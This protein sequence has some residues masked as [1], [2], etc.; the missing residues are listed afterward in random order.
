MH[1]GPARPII[2][3]RHHARG[4]LFVWGRSNNRAPSRGLFEGLLCSEGRRHARLRAFQAKDIRMARR[5]P[6]SWS[7][8][9]SG[10][11]QRSRG[12]PSC[13]P[14][15]RLRG[16]RAMMTAVMPICA[17]SARPSGRDDRRHAQGYS[18]GQERPSILAPLHFG[19]DLCAF[20]ARRPSRPWGPSSSQMTFV[21][22]GEILALS[23]AGRAVRRLKQE[24][25]N[26]A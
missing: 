19:G 2:G 9:I 23:L 1:T 24:N 16:S 17:P 13:P 25:P 22:L 26:Q 10:R 7:P 4:C 11:L 12:L 8:T 3:G 21:W 14:V 18:S 6:P 15:S 20:L 5:D